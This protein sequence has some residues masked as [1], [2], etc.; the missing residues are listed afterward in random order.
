MQAQSTANKKQHKQKTEPLGSSGTLA[1][2]R[3]EAPGVAVI[4]WRTW[5]GFDSMTSW[6]KAKLKSQAWMAEE[7]LLS[8]CHS[9]IIWLSERQVTPPWPSAIY[10]KEWPQGLSLHAHFQFTLHRVC[11]MQ[12]LWQ[13]S[14]HWTRWLW[15]S[16]SCI[17]SWPS[18]HEDNRVIFWDHKEACDFSAVWVTVWMNQGKRYCI[19]HLQVNV[20]NQT[21]SREMHCFGGR[22]KE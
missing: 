21:Q 13:K 1:P 12:Y 15:G 18:A 4:L 17:P 5:K 14:D 2:G 6:E 16:F 7:R 19:F 20:F 9:H 8:G 10:S 22:G 3:A 11:L